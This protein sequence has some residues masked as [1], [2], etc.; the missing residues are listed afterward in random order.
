MKI[1]WNQP[2]DLTP[3]EW[4]NSGLPMTVPTPIET[5]KFDLE[6]FYAPYNPLALSYQD[7]G[8]VTTIPVSNPYIETRE[9]TQTEHEEILEC[10]GIYKV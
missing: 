7:G 6:K 3:E 2:K 5:E 10:D 8:A 9:I 1:Y 4:E